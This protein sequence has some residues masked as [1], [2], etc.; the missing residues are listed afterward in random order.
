M[1]TV[2][3]HDVVVVGCGVAGCAAAIEAADA[4]ADVVVLEKMP[5]GQHGG[6][7]RVSGANWLQMRDSESAASYLRSLCRPNPVPDDVVNA[8]ASEI[9]R[10]TA[11]VQGLGGRPTHMAYPG[12]FPGCEGFDGYEGILHLGP[13]WG[14]EH[15]WRFLFCVAIE[16]VGRVRFGARAT[17]L[18]VDVVDGRR[19]VSGVRISVDGESTVLKARGGVVL[20]TGGF[21]NNAVMVRDYLGFAGAAAV[22]SPASEGDGI[23]LAIQ[24]GADLW[25]MNNCMPEPGFVP[26]G[27]VNGFQVRPPLDFGA[28]FVDIDGRRFV[29]EAAPRG[30]GHAVINGKHQLLPDREMWVVFDR[31]T[32]QAR[33]L[34]WT[35]EQGPWGWNKL[36][37]GYKWSEDNSKEIAQG[38]IKTADTVGE[39][40]Q[41]LGMDPAVLSETVEDF[42]HGCET[43]IDRFARRR[44]TLQALVEPPFAAYHCDPVFFFTCGG[45]RRNG[46]SEVLDVGGA[47]VEGLFAAGE[48]SSTYSWAM[49]SGMMVADAMAFG[50]IAGRNASARIRSLASREP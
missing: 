46:K 40:A 37:G 49:D 39:L 9:M 47:V 17:E 25:H 6:S 8:W 41:A 4:G 19:A 34:G 31:R 1:T 20:S 7:S 11:W 2:E 14:M 21:A 16:R 33:A 18:L 43:G 42:N 32:L 35:L 36:V 45:P 23:K 22:G 29:N 10:N 12:E 44:D 24:A 15:L 26:D 48:V 3:E 38:W 5:E 30:H 27:Y 28:L 50:R 13:T